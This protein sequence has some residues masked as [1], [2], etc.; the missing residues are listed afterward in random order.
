MNTHIKYCQVVESAALLTN[1]EVTHQFIRDLVNVVSNYW[2]ADSIQPDHS[3]SHFNN[4]KCSVLAEKLQTGQ[5]Q[6]E[7]NIVIK[8]ITMPNFLEPIVLHS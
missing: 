2:N 3:L 4:R 1:R 7:Y 8:L 6:S 5:I